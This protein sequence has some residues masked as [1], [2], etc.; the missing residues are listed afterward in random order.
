MPRIT[1][2][3]VVKHVEQ[4]EQAVFKSAIKLFIERGYNSVTMAD[5]AH[6]VGLARNSLYRYFPDKAAILVR[7]YRREMPHITSRAKASIEGTGPPAARVLTWAE[8]Q[9]A[10]TR[11]PEHQLLAALGNAESDLPATALAEIRQSHEQLMAPFR[12]T[13]RE[14]GL[15]DDELDA[16]VEL[17]WAVV[18]AQSQRELRTGEDPAGRRHLKAIIESLLS[19]PRVA[20]KPR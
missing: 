3:T 15:E 18:L 4:Q 1:A 9:I 10:Y 19:P 6:E 17:L 20:K 7:W 8:G 13:L 12:N 5:I 16:A 11:E 2:D 14:G